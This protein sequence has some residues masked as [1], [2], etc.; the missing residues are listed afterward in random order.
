MIPAG[1]LTIATAYV[2]E[3]APKTR[4]LWLIFGLAIALRGLNAGGHQYWGYMCRIICASRS[5]DTPK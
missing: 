1:I 3:G 2:A 5:G 4:A